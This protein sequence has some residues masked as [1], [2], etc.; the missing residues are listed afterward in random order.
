MDAAQ[1]IYPQA[2]LGKGNS[3]KSVGIDMSGKGAKL[4]KN[5]R[6]TTEISKSAYSL[7]SKEIDIVED[8]NFVRP[9]LLDRH[10]DFPIYRNFSNAQ[11]QNMYVVKQIK[12][13]TKE[14]YKLSDI[15]VVSKINKNLEIIN[16]I[17]HE[18][19]IDT[20]L[21]SGNTIVDFQLDKVK[22]LTMHSIKGL[23]FKVVILVDLNSNII[24]YVKDDWNEEQRQIE[25]ITERKLLY[26]GMTR[27]QQKLFMCSYGAESKFIDDIDKNFLIM[28]SGCRM[29]AYY[30]VQYSEYISKN[31]VKDETSEEESVRQWVIKEIKSTYG[32]PLEL[33]E[34]EYPVKL[35]SQNGRVDLVI[36]N[37]V[38]NEPYICIET[39]KRDVDI[40]EA[41]SQLKSYM[42]V[43]GAKYG[44]ATNGANIAF[45]DSDY[46]YIK[47]IP[48]CSINIL[49]S[50]TQKYRVICPH[51]FSEQVFEVDLSAR[52]VIINNK[53]LLQSETTKLKVYSDIAAGL[54]IE[55]IDDEKGE[56][57]IP[58][59]ILNNNNNNLFMLKV[60][61]DSM[62]GAGIDDEDY[63][64]IEQTSTVGNN[65]IAAVEYNGGA[66]LKRVVRMG[67]TILLMSEN[68]AYEPINISEGDLKIAGKLVSIIKK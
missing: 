26:V 4:T 5:Y 39:K 18:N 14:G 53:N 64:I 34:L 24:P 48:K 36:K 63:V 27:A 23:E 50:S 25:E 35:F 17:L 41:T 47:D 32:Y 21:C 13:L 31:K 12:Q 49:P 28:Q 52:E 20:F 29:S 33:I 51:T 66:T 60:K 37:G 11:M 65:Q 43:T 62:V 61:G 54:P 58:T 55:I 56:F 40:K 59:S 44:I 42:Q 10:G 38:T 22:L 3:F 57:I 46:N 68:E 19:K 30:P 9:S 67:S 45:I 15:A 16:K 2:W 1:S 6:T 8:D 7:L